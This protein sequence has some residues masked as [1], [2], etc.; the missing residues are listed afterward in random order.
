MLSESLSKLLIYV[1]STFSDISQLELDLLVLSIKSIAIFDERSA[2]YL[3]EGVKA[4][5]QK[6]RKSDSEV[7]LE[8]ILRCV[9][10]KMRLPNAIFDKKNQIGEEDEE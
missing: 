8:E 7:M 9:V 3:F 2:T 1:S 6:V 4:Y 5:I 10:F